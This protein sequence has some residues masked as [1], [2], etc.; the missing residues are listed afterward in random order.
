MITF[1]SSFKMLMKFYQI[2]CIVKLKKTFQG[3]L[4]MKKLFGALFVAIF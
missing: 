2:Q 4:N 1:C 3:E